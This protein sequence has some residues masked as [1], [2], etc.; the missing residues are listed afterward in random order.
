MADK[1]YKLWMPVKSSINNELNR[2]IGFKRREIWIANIG[3]NIGFEE[4]GK[5]ARF[6]RP[7]LII[8]TYGKN[9]CYIVPLSTTHK[10]GR[11]YLPIEGHTGKESVVLLSQA[12]IIDSARLRRKIGFIDEDSFEIVKEKLK[13]V[14]GL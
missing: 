6:V 10:R 5:G 2:P 1:D 14:L 3:E 12:R 7:V 8:R 9:M 11:F 4:D 13:G